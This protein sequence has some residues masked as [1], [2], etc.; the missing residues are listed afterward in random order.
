MVLLRGITIA[1]LDAGFSIH[2]KN[3][4]RRRRIMKTP[5]IL[6]FL[7]V[8]GA[9]SATSV[10]FNFNSLAENATTAQIQSYM[11]TQ[12]TNAGCTGCTV[13][14]TGAFADTTYNADGHVTGPG[15]VSGTGKSTASLTLGNTGD[16]S[17]LDATAS[18]LTST[19]NG[20]Y[21]TFLATTNDGATQT[22]SQITLKFSGFTV[23]GTGNSFAYEIFPDLSCTALTS[24]ACGG[25][26]VG[27][28]Y[29]NQPDFKF[30]ING[31]TPVTSFGTNGIQY[32]VTP[33]TTNGNTNNS[34]LSSAETAPQYIGT[35]SG[36]LNTATEMDFVDWPATI[37]VDDLVLNWTKTSSPVP[38]PGSVLLLGTIA[39]G[40]A[41]RKKLRKLV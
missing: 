14:V 16:S 20:S 36:S 4:S 26:A 3:C 21:D 33:G 25:N 1:Q 24:S 10:T 22:G 2:T 31:S 18:N 32:G 35:W 9:A 6:I 40:L 15:S 7:A 34:L 27:G 17:T 37:G 38:E 8:A 41:F 39:T 5:R 11:N 13:T 19:V 30:D 12:L 23:G 28:I 29:P